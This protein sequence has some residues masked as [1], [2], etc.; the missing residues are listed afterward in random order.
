MPEVRSTYAEAAAAGLVALRA[1]GLEPSDF[2]KEL[3]MKVA[4]R[5]ITPKQMTEMLVEHH[6][7]QSL[8]VSRSR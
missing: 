5:E 4:S 6:H 2:A 8:V 7:K 3:A 1:Q